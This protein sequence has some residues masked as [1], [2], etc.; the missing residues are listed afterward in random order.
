MKPIARKVSIAFLC[1]LGWIIA[2][3][4][5]GVVMGWPEGAIR[6]VDVY[7]YCLDHQY[8]AYEPVGEIGSGVWYCIGIRDG[9][10]RTQRVNK[11]MIRKW[12]AENY[13]G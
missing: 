13:D 1:L 11:D 9:Q 3:L 12:Q 2:V 10:T 7:E 6:G 5:I 4:I 8:S